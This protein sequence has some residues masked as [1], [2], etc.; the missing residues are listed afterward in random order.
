MMQ[1][2]KPE[3][4]NGQTRAG[5]AFSPRVDICETEQELILFADLPGVKPD[6]LDLNFENGELTLRGRCQA[7]AH[8]LTAHDFVQ[9]EYGVGDFFRAFAVTEDIDADK[10]T[11]DLKQGVLTVHLPKSERVKPRKIRIASETSR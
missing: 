4:Q 3:T 1:T 7:T 2:S 10:I 11:A 8:D 6:D 5:Q 9:Q